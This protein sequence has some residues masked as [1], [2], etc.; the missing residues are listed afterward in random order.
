MIRRLK[1]LV[2]LPV[3]LFNTGCGLG[4]GVDFSPDGK[5][6]ATTWLADSGIRIAVCNIDGSGFRIVPKSEASGPPVWSPNGQYVLFSSST[7]L[8]AYDVKNN[9]LRR[10]APWASQFC[11]TWSADSQQVAYAASQQNDL[12]PP[13]VVWK[14]VSSA[15]ELLRVPLPAKPETKLFGSNMVWLPESWGVAYISVEGDVYTVES[16]KPS[17]IT[18]TGDVTALWVSRDG[19]Q[20]GWVRSLREPAPMLVLHRYDLAT[21][22]LVEK[23]TRIDFTAIKPPRNYQLDNA[24]GLPS[25]DAEKMLISLVSKRVDGKHDR[26]HV[27]LLDL[28]RGRWRLLRED[29]TP[30][31]QEASAKYLLIPAWSRDGS[32]IAVTGL[33]SQLYLW[34]ARGDGTGGR[35]I[36]KTVLPKK[37]SSLI[38]IKNR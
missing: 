17:R 8:Y 31:N 15:R 24:L 4:V 22:T 29:A 6:I 33:G 27:Y 20:L 28:Q 36:R 21:R 18:R 16:G 19:K 5:Q 12:D 14:D 1:V 30:V 35:F 2:L 23:P 38:S 13:E 11:Y 34:V 10:L 32:Q 25:P 3:L 9:R 26:Q 7:G 37:H